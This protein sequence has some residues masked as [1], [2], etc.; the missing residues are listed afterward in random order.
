[1]CLSQPH[2]MHQQNFVCL[3]F[4]AADAGKQRAAR[5]LAGWRWGTGV[6]NADICL[7]KRRAKNASHTWES[8]WMGGCCSPSPPPLPDI[9]RARARQATRRRCLYLRA[10]G[11]G[12]RR[13][14][15]KVCVSQRM[16]AG[17]VSSRNNTLPW[18]LL[19]GRHLSLSA[20]A[21]GKAGRRRVASRQPETTGVVTPAA[22]KWEKATKEK[23]GEEEY[24]KK[25]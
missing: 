1:M 3:Y 23:N 18:D 13:R 21:L 11:A 17:V 9:I 12:A 8:C 14:L 22:R 25:P 24:R 16:C 7:W 6:V 10:D 4:H 20:E 5:L 2:F 15:C 19:N